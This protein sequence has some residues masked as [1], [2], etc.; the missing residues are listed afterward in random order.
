MTVE[1]T[2]TISQFKEAINKEGSIPA[3]QQRLIFKG[4]VLTN[5]EATLEFY[6]TYKSTYLVYNLREKHIQSETHGG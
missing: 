5:E 3:V 1:S 6:G 2:A 4:K